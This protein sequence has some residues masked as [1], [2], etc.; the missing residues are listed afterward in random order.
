M[1]TGTVEDRL[2]I[3]ELIEKFGVGAMRLDPQLWGE[4]WADNG[5]WKLVSHPAPVVGKANI[6]EAFA[7]VTDY[8]QFL[9]MG[10]FPYDLVFDGDRATG[11]AYCQETI[12]PKSGGR[13]FVVGCFD[14]EY[15]K[16]NGRW[17]FT[18]RFY[19]VLGV[20]DQ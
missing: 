11:K 3:R 12:F 8:A 20:T 2:A 17:L 5:A 4:T 16:E 10:A 6:I 9:G 1:S 13:K 14:D 7:K 19:E 15:V 18:K